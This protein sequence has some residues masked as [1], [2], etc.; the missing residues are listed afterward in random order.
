MVL[1][2]TCLG[3]VCAAGLLTC[4]SC[5]PAAAGEVEDVFSIITSDY[6]A[7]IP[8]GKA[9]LVYKNFCPNNPDIQSVI[10]YYV[11]ANN[12]RKYYVEKIP[13]FLGGANDTSYKSENSSM[14]SRSFP[15]IDW[16]YNSITWSGE[17]MKFYYLV[18]SSW[19]LGPIFNICPDRKAKPTG[20]LVMTM[21]VGEDYNLLGTDTVP[22]QVDCK[23]DNYCNSG[24]S[25]FNPY[26]K[27]LMIT[28]E[29]G[30][31]CSATVFSSD[32]VDPEY[33]ET[34]RLYRNE[35][36]LFA[37][38]GNFRF[39]IMQKEWVNPKQKISGFFSYDLN[40]LT[41][42]GVKYRLIPAGK[43]WNKGIW[44]LKGNG[45]YHEKWIY[46]YP[47]GNIDHVYEDSLQPKYHKADKVIVTLFPQWSYSTDDRT[48]RFVLYPKKK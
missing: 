20:R 13:N 11:I 17:A 34:N 28:R 37:P 39:E 47:T 2:R 14:S 21:A 40:T 32:R 25:D 38:H 8:E 3:K 22:Y 31:F 33:T 18:A 9:P 6:N 10:D 19:A 30:G 23:T 26:R 15:L 43:P 1:N 29:D 4:I 24:L 45:E 27:V 7:S 44:Y 35:I 48:E 5:L 36:R 16:A 12:K 41:I 46:I 42:K